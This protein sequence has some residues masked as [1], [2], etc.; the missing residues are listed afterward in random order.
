MKKQYKKYELK[1]YLTIADLTK[2]NIPD[3]SG[4]YPHGSNVSEGTINTY[5]MSDCADAKLEAPMTD[6]CLEA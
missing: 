6:K 3:D 5:N 2:D 4:V 1:K